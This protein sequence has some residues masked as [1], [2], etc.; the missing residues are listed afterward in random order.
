[1]AKKNFENNPETVQ[2]IQMKLNR[3]N[4]FYEW[5][6]SLRTVKYKSYIIIITIWILKVNLFICRAIG[7]D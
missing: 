2:V 7:M 1:M 6:C 4:L 3:E 5:I